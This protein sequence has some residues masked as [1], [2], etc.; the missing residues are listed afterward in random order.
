MA[1]ICDTMTRGSAQSCGISGPRCRGRYRIRASGMQGQI[2]IFHCIARV[3]EHATNEA[4][5]S[6]GAS[7]HAFMQKLCNSVG[8]HSLCWGSRLGVPHRNNFK[9]I[10]SCDMS[11]VYMRPTIFGSCALKS[12]LQRIRVGDHLAKSVLCDVRPFFGRCA[13]QV[14]VGVPRILCEM[15]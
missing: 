12:F 6:S 9:L 15:R 10:T 4:K 2:S 1:V 8:S 13:L 11:G 3:T 14:C 7:L 5:P